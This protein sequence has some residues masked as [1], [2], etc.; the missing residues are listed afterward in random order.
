MKNLKVLKI[1][2]MIVIIMGI[3]FISSLKVN[4]VVD[5]PGKIGYTNT[6]PVSDQ[7]TA[8]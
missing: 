4:A 2:M 1:L 7:D 8:A 5:K 6:R 3:L